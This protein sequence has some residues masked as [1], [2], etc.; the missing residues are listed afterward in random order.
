MVF[1]AGVVCWDNLNSRL[2]RYKDGQKLTILYSDR[3]PGL[4]G[5]LAEILAELQTLSCQFSDR[6]VRSS[7]NI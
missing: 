2:S 7:R 4:K 3:E 5:T 6:R 1:Y